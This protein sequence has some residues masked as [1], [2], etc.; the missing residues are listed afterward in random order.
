MKRLQVR[1]AGCAPNSLLKASPIRRVKP[2]MDADAPDLPC[3]EPRAGRGTQGTKIQSTAQCSKGLT[4][5]EV[6]QNQ[7]RRSA[8]ACV[9][10]DQNAAPSAALQVRHHPQGTG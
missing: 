3:T 9:A 8:P 1:V 7:R 5:D 10:V 2:L 6:R 4:S